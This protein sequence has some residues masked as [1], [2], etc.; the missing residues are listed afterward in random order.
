MNKFGSYLVCK[1]H[2]KEVQNFL[3]NFFGEKKGR[4][5]HGEWISFIIP[6]TDFLINLMEGDDQPMTQNMTFE[7]YCDSMEEL[8]EFSKKYHSKIEN[9]IATSTGKD[10]RYNFIEIPGPQGIC[11]VEMSFCED[12]V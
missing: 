9:F 6:N 12:M 4:Y 5:N 7:I 10:Y 11:K 1:E 8:K 3:K 2:I